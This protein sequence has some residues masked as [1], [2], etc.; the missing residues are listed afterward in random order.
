[1]V[2]W[3]YDAAGNLLSDGSQTYTYDAPGRMSSTTRTGTTTSYQ[4]MGDGVLAAQTS[5]LTATR[6]TLDTV[7]ALPER[8]RRRRAAR[9]PGMCAAGGRS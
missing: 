6:Y 2:G 5:G 1:M 8:R 4:Y 3:A 9:R 7:G